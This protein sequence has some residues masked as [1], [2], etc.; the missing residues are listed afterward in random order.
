MSVSLFTRPI[1]RLPIVPMATAD[2]ADTDCDIYD[3]NA[4]I[5]DCLLLFLQFCISFTGYLTVNH[6]VSYDDFYVKFMLLRR[7]TCSVSRQFSLC[8]AVGVRVYLIRNTFYLHKAYK[9]QD[10]LA[11]NNNVIRDG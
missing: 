5:Y 2:Y 4:G 8:C 1:F 10:Q 3:D 7:L 11:S 6:Q 9:D